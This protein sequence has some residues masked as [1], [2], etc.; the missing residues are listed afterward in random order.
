MKRL[1]LSC[2]L[3]SLITLTG[4]SKELGDFTVLTTKTV[5]LSNFSIHT[6]SHSQRV[7]GESVGYMIL[8]FPNNNPNLKD[9]ID[10]TL[11]N[12]NAY[13]LTDATIQ[14]DVFFLPYIYGQDKYVVEGQPLL[15][16]Q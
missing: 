4:C 16:I 5:D 1:L 6:L 8:W 10:V 15:R 13:M 9:A 11:E 2:L 7:K 12:N 14:Y 3:G